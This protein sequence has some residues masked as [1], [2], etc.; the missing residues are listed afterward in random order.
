MET[1][2][3]HK[4]YNVPCLGL[5]VIKQVLKKKC[6]LLI[7]LTSASTEKADG[8]LYMCAREHLARSSD[9]ILKGLTSCK[10]PYTVTDKVQ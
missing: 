7:R 8:K 10:I 9:C 2:G 5:Q 1:S 3:G 6:C 4:K